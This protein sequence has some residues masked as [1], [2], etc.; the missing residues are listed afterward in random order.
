M[1]NYLLVSEKS[2]QQSWV[3]PPAQF[4]C[5]SLNSVPLSIQTHFPYCHKM[6]VAIPGLTLIHHIVKKEGLIPFFN[7]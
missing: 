3:R 4:L 6:A 2:S 5:N 1:G 7:Y